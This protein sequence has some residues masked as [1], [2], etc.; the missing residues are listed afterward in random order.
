MYGS[1][2]KFFDQEGNPVEDGIAFHV[3]HTLSSGTLSK[4]EI[5]YGLSYETKLRYDDGSGTY[6]E[7]LSWVA[8]TCD[9]SGSTKVMERGYGLFGWSGELREAGFTEQRIPLA[10][11]SGGTTG[12]CTSSPLSPGPRDI[13]L[14]PCPEAQ[15]STWERAGQHIAANRPAKQAVATFH[16]FGAPT[17]V[18]SWRYP[19]QQTIKHNAWLLVQPQGQSQE[20][21]LTN[22]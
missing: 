7:A 16:H 20:D 17:W 3:L 18:T 8:P 21:G 15:L 11:N 1:S 6:S 5:C 9:P 19:T 22:V 2:M 12:C 10:P 4:N 13:D 14:H